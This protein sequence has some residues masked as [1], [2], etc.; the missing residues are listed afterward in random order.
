MNSKKKFENILCETI[1]LGSFFFLVFE[2]KNTKVFLMDSVDFYDN[3]TLDKTIYER[4][5]GLI[6]K[7]ISI[8]RV[9]QLISNN[10]STNDIWWDANQ[11]SLEYFDS[12]IYTNIFLKLKFIFTNDIEEIALDLVFKKIMLPIAY[13]KILFIQTY[14]ILKTNELNKLKVFESHY[15]FLDIKTY[16]GVESDLVFIKSK[17]SS[18]WN[19]LKST[20]FLIS[21]PFL[22][23]ILLQRGVSFRSISPESFDV[24]I[25]L[26]FGFPRESELKS[27]VF[28]NEFIKSSKINPSKFL[29]IEKNAHGRNTSNKDF[30]ELRE[31]AKKIGTNIVHEKKLKIPVVLFFKKFIFY[32]FVKNFR[33]FKLF[34]FKDMSFAG[35][36]EIQRLISMLI[37][38]ELF[39]AYFRTKI[40][41][42]RD[43]YDV[44]HVIRTA[45]QNKY[46]LLNV[47]IQHSAFIEPKYY[48]FLVWIYFDRYYIQADE[49]INLWS[50]YFS[51]NKS[52]LSVGTQRDFKILEALRDQSIKAKFE[53]KY[54]FSTNILMII[55]SPSK[56]Y[57]PEWLIKKKYKNFW[58]IL[59]IDPNLKLILRPRN[60]QAKESFISMFPEINQHL[61]TGK[62][63][64]EE[65]DFTTQQLLAY[66]DI[67]ISEDS[68]SSILETAHFNHIYLLSINMRYPMNHLLKGILFENFEEICVQI[69][70][71]LKN[72]KI[73][74]DNQET[75]NKLRSFYTLPPSISAFTKVIDNIY[76]DFLN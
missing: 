69:K 59:D 11:K 2:K 18:I 56:T 6:R 45:C 73:P 71:Y 61:E 9:P 57:S 34:L 54:S 46:G 3:H 65:K 17:L 20:I 30:N 16:L 51:L 41:I 28:D 44:Q 52:L 26:V 8:V 19:F 4:I 58:K 53:K 32:A 24:A 62:I 60:V 35:L 70:Q 67:F 68:S 66:C 72:K 74:P 47:G 7:D 5:L 22:V 13:K 39:L 36:K 10:K 49:F 15:D 25:P 12:D 40:Y 63:I 37:L 38:E 50:P 27:N 31:N 48:P 64:F 42:S 43:D 29:F 14:K 21:S 76:D 33:L 23:R 1:D 55:T 75:I